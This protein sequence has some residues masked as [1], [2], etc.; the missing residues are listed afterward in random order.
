MSK[1]YERKKVVV[2]GGAGFVGSHLVDELMK[3]GAYVVVID[4]FSRGVNR[5][6]GATYL[7][8]DV[9]DKP[10]MFNM[11][12]NTF[13]VF[14]LA[15][16]VGGVEYNQFHQLEML[17]KNL[18]CQ[19]SPLVAANHNAVE[20]FL[21]VS[22]VCVYPYGQTAP[23][24]EKGG[25]ID[26]PH[27]AFSNMGYGWSKRMG[28]LGAN[29]L[30]SKRI[31]KMVIARPTNIFG[32]RD[33][34]DK[35]SSHVIPAL[36]RKA[37]FDPKIIVNGSGDV[38]RHFAYVKDMARAMADLLERGDNRTAYNLAPTKG[39]KISIKRL[40][41]LIR[42]YTGMEN[43]SVEFVD[44]FG[45][46]DDKRYSDTSRATALGIENY[47]VFSTALKKTIEWYRQNN[48]SMDWGN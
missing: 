12:Q 14:N 40:V 10:A 19:L 22:S 33:Y 23:A 35:E 8:F 25:N 34:F 38:V 47:G 48:H 5:R 28:E 4:N 39:G 24:I 21:Q 1:F 3:R 27:P 30:F 43:K 44:L 9:G 37:L 18:N 45:G 41:H 20:H 13:A 29:A 42:G 36:I 46:G 2:T 32:E 16:H 7:A 17:Q 6:S 26:S 31:K 15:A 11:L